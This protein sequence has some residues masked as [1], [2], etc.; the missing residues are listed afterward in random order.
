MG[1]IKYNWDNA[2]LPEGYKVQET[3]TE[4][5]VTTITIVYSPSPTTNVQT[6]KIVVTKVDEDGNPLEGALLQILKIV[7]GKKEVVYEWTSN[8]EEEIIYLPNGEYILHEETAPKGY[9]IAED[10]TITVKIEVPDID[11]GVDFSKEPCERN[12]V[13]RKAFSTTTPLRSF[14]RM[15]IARLLKNMI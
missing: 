13:L 7:D 14:S 5:T 3:K 1:R 11:V 2:S 9:E 6:A 8:G 4:G 10:Q 12:T 15:R